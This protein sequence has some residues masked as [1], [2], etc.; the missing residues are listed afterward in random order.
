MKNKKILILSILALNVV[1]IFA[2]DGNL[3]AKTGKTIN[4]NEIKIIDGKVATHEEENSNEDDFIRLRRMRYSDGEGST[5]KGFKYLSRWHEYLK[6]V[7]EEKAKKAK[8]ERELADYNLEKARIEKENEKIRR[9]NESLN[10][11]YYN[12]DSSPTST[13]YTNVPE[14]GS[15]DVDKL[16]RENASDSK[17]G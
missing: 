5:K 17:K 1:N 7:E 3:K 2:N 12:D 14:G 9:Y 15:V 10:G 11:S 6:E 4:V 13:T 8:Y 16:N